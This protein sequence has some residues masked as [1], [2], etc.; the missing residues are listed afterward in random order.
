MS[1]WQDLD[2]WWDTEP[3]GFDDPNTYN[4]IKNLIKQERIK[5]KER[6]RELVEV[7]E[8]IKTVTMFHSSIIS[9]ETAKY[10]REALEKHRS[11]GGE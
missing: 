4:G 8:N 6:E 5:A 10:A 1:E 7:L 9:Q 2:E 11:M 3:F